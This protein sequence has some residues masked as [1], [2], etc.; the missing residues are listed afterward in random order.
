MA[1]GSGVEADVDSGPV[2]NGRRAV[3][4]G[5]SRVVGALAMR[6]VDVRNGRFVNMVE[7]KRKV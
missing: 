2:A 6:R 4:G 5:V 3:V 7:N 1:G